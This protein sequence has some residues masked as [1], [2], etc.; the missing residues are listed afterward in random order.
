MIKL[1]QFFDVSIFGIV[2]SKIEMALLDSS[3]KIPAQIHLQPEVTTRQFC[4]EIN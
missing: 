3:G 2:S 4:F 1:L